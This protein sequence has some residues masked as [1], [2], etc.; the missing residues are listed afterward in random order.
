VIAST[1]ERP[2]AFDAYTA[3]LEREEGAAQLYARLMRR[4]G[5]LAETG[6]A[7]QLAK[8]ETGSGA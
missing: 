1:L 2:L 3:A 7:E 8:L 4:A 5:R 6:L